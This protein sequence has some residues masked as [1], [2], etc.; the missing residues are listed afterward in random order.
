MYSF[1]S[2]NKKFTDTVADI[3]PGSGY[4]TD[5]RRHFVH[6]RRTVMK[7]EYNDG[8]DDGDCT[9]DHH[10]REVHAYKTAGQIS[11]SI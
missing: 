3:A 7:V 10:T 4:C 11:K 5:P 6:V 9:H 8:H 2:V 1:Q